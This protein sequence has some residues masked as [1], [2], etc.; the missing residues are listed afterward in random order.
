MEAT[1]KA[2]PG[3]H[4]LRADQVGQN[5]SIIARVEVPFVVDEVKLTGSPGEIT[6]IR[7]N[8]LWRIARRTYG[9]CIYYTTIFEAN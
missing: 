5:D 9:D 2:T 6:V 1:G 3:N 4:T 7:G 8:S